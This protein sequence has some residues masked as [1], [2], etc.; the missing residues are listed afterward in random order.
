MT[1]HWA[2]YVLCNFD[3]YI[4]FFYS[5]GPEC[6]MFLIC[7]TH[8]LHVLV[9]QLLR[10][11]GLIFGVK[12]FSSIIMNTI[13][14]GGGDLYNELTSGWSLK[15]LTFERWVLGWNPC[16]FCSACGQKSATV[17]TQPPLHYFVITDKVG[18]HTNHH[19]IKDELE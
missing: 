5:D 18:I 16:Q 19:I 3:N 1:W 12:K 7:N 17:I 14:I 4:T 6:N 2:V 11:Q 10:F 13:L 15:P 8:I 9:I